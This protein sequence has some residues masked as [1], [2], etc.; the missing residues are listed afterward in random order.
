MKHYLRLSERLPTDLVFDKISQNQKGKIKLN[1]FELNCSSLRMKTF[2]KKGIR[3]TH[4]SLT[5]SFF[6]IEKAKNALKEP[7][8][9]NLYAMNSEGNEV[10]FTQDHIYPKSKG[11]PSTLEN[12]QTMCGPCNWA[13]KDTLI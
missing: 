12:S 9:L 10:L 5:A 6:Y 13:K 7:P 3:C 1:G 11:G 8:H 2:F 4:C